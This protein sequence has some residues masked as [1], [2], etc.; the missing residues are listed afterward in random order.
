MKKVGIVVLIAVLLVVGAFAQARATYRAGTYEGAA[1]GFGGEIKVSVTVDASRVVSVTIVSN[2]ETPGIGSRAI[3]ALP[4]RIVTAQ[5]ITVDNV[6]GATLS[7]QGI[8]NAVAQ[9]LEKAKA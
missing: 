4:A 3:E 2:A 1:N 8:K 6:S 9:A 5:G 7:S